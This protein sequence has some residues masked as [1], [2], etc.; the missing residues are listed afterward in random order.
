MLKRLYAWTLAKARHRYAPWWLAFFSF[1]E[2]SIFPTPPDPI[3]A[4]L[5][6]AK[7]RQVVRLVLNCTISSVLGGLLGYA[8]GYF[9]FESI[10]R[11]VLQATHAMGQFAAVQ[12]CFNHYGA[13]IILVKGLSPIPYK[14][15]TITA[16]VT[17][18]DLTT[19]V[20]ASVV[21]RGLRFAAVG[22][23][24]YWFDYWIESPFGRFV[25]RYA[26]ELCVAAVAALIAAY[27][28]YQHFQGANNAPLCG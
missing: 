28:I 2:S 3:L 4:L 1:L 14:L 15:I 9:L 26:K 5:V 24:M 19:F 22:A 18:L 27:F 6:L 20:V 21:S 7:R 23:I 12:N 17:K 16:G 25:R 10:G 11:P 13:L 8:I